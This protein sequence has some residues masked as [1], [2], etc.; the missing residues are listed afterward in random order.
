MFLCRE[1]QVPLPNLFAKEGNSKGQR[2]IHTFPDSASFFSLSHIR[3]QCVL[4]LCVCVSQFICPVLLSVVVV[5]QAISFHLLEALTGGLLLVIGSVSHKAHSL[6]CPLFLLTQ[7]NMSGTYGET[8]TTI[9][10]LLVNIFASCVWKGFLFCPLSLLVL[11]ER[12]IRLNKSLV[13]G[14]SIN[15]LTS[16]GVFGTETLLAT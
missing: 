1:A 9:I 7:F 2:H 12:W 3:Y 5:P 16:D 14:P 8:T 13:Q 6:V 10:T 4:C 15:P 11:S